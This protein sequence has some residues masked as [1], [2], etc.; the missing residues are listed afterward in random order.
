[1]KKKI[2]NKPDVIIVGA[3]PAG[4]F[5]ALEI[6]KKTNLNVL[7]IDKG[8]DIEERAEIIKSKDKILSNP[9]VFVSGWGGAGAFSDGKLNLSKDVGGILSSFVKDNE[10]DEL[11]EYVDKIYLQ[12]GSPKKIYGT[13]DDKIEELKNRAILCDLH[14]I[15]SKI[16]H[17]G[18]EMCIP[19]ISA[20]KQ[21]LLDANVS[22]LTNCE[23]KEIIVKNNKVVGIKTEDG[24]IYSCKYLILAPGRS[25]ANWLKSEIR[26]LGLRTINNPVDLGIR[27]EVPYEVLDFF[28]KVVYELK[29]IF[30][31][32]IFDD[33]VRTFCM[34][35]QGEVIKEYHNGIVTVN[36]HSFA[37]RKTQN[38]NFA[39]LVSTN[40]TEPF[41]EPIAYGQYIAQLANILGDG[42]ILQ[43]LGDLKAG[44]RS[45]WERI[46]RGLI[47]P[48]LTDA[49]PGD[50]SFVLPYRY[51][52][53]I[54][55][56]L[57]AF[58]KLCPGINSRH[59]L[60]Y[61]IEVK[62]YSSRCELSPQLQTQIEGMYACGDGAGITR[63]LVQASISGV[64]AAR[65]II[66]K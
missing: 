26:R 57:E 6:S 37:K 28:T 1:M 8:S 17:L 29:L 47:K 64:L 23:A 54:M 31:S 30:H 66:E 24:K 50:L 51:L 25:G 52:T 45:T 10:L 22:I 21:A 60:I 61:G 49:T 27:V 14:L 19:V 7:I 55:E 35:P 46:E 20:M 11:I 4:I 16:R 41:K 56:F 63:G 2:K 59:T 34:C 18:R 58:D 38:T 15:P 40:F 62:F 43:R 12:Y 32:K 9:S 48:T 3:G 53:D 42:V 13:D 33:K 5:A 65:G 36:G 44:R 39:I